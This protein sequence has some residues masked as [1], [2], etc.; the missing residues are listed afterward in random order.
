MISGE[1]VF[2]LMDTHGLPLDLINEELRSRQLCFNVVEFVEVALASKNF[3]YEKIK[4]RLVEAMLPEKREA[5]VAELDSWFARGGK[6]WQTQ[7]SNI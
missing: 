1:A 6:T 2:R 4:G 7:E 5:F 3:T